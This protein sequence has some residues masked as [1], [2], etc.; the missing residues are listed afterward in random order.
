[1][2]ARRSFALGAR[3]DRSLRALGAVLDLAFS[4]VWESGGAHI[5]ILGPL[6]AGVRI[7][8]AWI[9]TW[10]HSDHQHVTRKEPVAVGGIACCWCG[11]CGRE[12][13]PARPPER[14]GVWVGPSLL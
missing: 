9:D 1:M 11:R 14:P 5:G 2:H 8:Q 12:W 3:W 7:R 4:D 13:S 6:V 10:A